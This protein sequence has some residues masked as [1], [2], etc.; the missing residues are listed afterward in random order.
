L[1]KFAGDHQAGTSP[2][3]IRAGIY[4]LQHPC[5]RSL[6]PVWLL[7]VVWHGFVTDPITHL[8]TSDKNTV[9]TVLAT[10]AFLQ[11][12]MGIAMVDNN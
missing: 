4:F 8:Q 6:V 10:A 1:Q 2:A 3:G 12:E 5:N 9:Y 7:P 11:R